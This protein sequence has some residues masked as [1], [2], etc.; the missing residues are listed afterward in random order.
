M[1]SFF[2]FFS[3]KTNGRLLTF[4]HYLFHSILP[5]FSSPSFLP[6]FFFFLLLL[7]FDLSLHS[8]FWSPICWSPLVALILWLSFTLA[9]RLFILVILLYLSIIIISLSLHYQ[10]LLLVL[11]PFLIL[12]YRSFIPILLPSCLCTAAFSSLYYC[13]YF[14]VHRSFVLVLEQSYLYIT[15]L[16]QLVFSLSLY[17]HSSTLIHHRPSI[18]LQYW[19]LSTLV[20]P[21]LCFRT[22]AFYTWAFLYPYAIATFKCDIPLLSTRPLEDTLILA[23]SEELI[24]YICDE[25]F[26]NFFHV[27]CDF[28][29]YFWHYSIA[30][31]YI[32]LCLS[33]DGQLS[34]IFWSLFIWSTHGY[35]QQTINRH[36]SIS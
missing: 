33:Y 3:N 2:F 30:A 15:A 16:M 11:S 25:P 36:T 12:V 1:T 9:Y 31:K 14:P 23:K 5:L 28:L 17:Y 26:F 18:L 19:H 32:Y 7:I 35:K 13:L 20:L 24:A 10:L 6:R 22:N 29:F 8:F 4:L 27:F 21:S 34:F